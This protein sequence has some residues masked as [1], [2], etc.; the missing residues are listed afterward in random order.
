MWEIKNGDGTYKTLE[1][2]KNE[3]REAII[4]ELNGMSNGDALCL[5]NYIR[6]HNGDNPLH[7][8]SESEINE[9]FSD[10]S[11]YDLL[12][13]DYDDYSDFFYLDWGDPEFTDDVWEN[14]DTE[15]IAENIL[16]GKT[17]GDNLTWAIADM[18]VDYNQAKEY[19]E[20]MN[21]YRT[22]GENLL[23]KFTNCEAD[24]TDL[25]QYISRITKTDEAWRKGV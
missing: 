6:E 22:E 5:G 4:D 12:N 24:V 8:N 1:E 2:I 11:A 23:A 18:I 25:L 14:L 20:N 7:E 13:M 17:F 15:E 16:N 19:L 9:V 21:K 3:V 10:W